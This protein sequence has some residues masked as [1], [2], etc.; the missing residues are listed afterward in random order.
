MII[1]FYFMCTMLTMADEIWNIQHPRPFPKQHYY[2]LQWEQADFVQLK[3]GEWALRPKRKVDSKLKKAIREKYYVLQYK[4][5]KQ[6]N[7][8]K[9]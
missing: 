4:Q 5:R 8:K 7:S 1:K 9:K 2:M 3:N 6:L